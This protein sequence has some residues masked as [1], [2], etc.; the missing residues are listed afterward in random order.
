VAADGPAGGDDASTV[1]KRAAVA[2][3]AMKASVRAFIQPIY[4]RHCERDVNASSTE[5]RAV[6]S[7]T[8]ASLVHADTNSAF[9]AS[10]GALRPG[11]RGPGD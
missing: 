11:T 8:P 3:S 1:A 6:F 7:I 2:P 10:A 5:I 4:P 9:F